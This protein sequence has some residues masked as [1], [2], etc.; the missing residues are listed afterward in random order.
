MLTI[1]FIGSVFIFLYVD[2]A[3]FNFIAPLLIFL[4]AVAPSCSVQ[5][6]CLEAQFIF[7]LHEAITITPGV[8]HTF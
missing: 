2:E 5:L 3:H 6:L 7:C 4:S 8:S 1:I